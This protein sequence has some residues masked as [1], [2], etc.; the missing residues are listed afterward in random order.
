MNKETVMPGIKILVKWSVTKC[1]DSLQ[2]NTRD[3]PWGPDNIS[4][5]RMT[6]QTI[7][8]RLFAWTASIME[9]EEFVFK[10]LFEE[11]L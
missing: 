3:K 10:N 8:D 1:E 6:N 11:K 9:R 4:F 2:S 5:P 7:G